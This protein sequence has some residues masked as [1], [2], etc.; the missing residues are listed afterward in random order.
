MRSPFASDSESSGGPSPSWDRTP[1]Q[2]R[3]RSTPASSVPEEDEEPEVDEGSDLNDETPSDDHP[4][5]SPRPKKSSGSGSQKQ[6]R[7]SSDGSASA[8]NPYADT[9][10]GR[11]NC[12]DLLRV[13]CVLENKDLWEKFNELGTEMIITKTGRSLRPTQA[14]F[15][16]NCG[17]M[18]RSIKNQRDFTGICSNFLPPTLPSG[19][20]QRLLKIPGCHSKVHAKDTDLVHVL[21]FPDAEAT[22]N[23]V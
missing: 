14:Y 18:Y 4:G 15:H 11:C 7:S 9:L 2:K 16:I 21:L 10:K 5:K 3:D 12:Q 23:V 8:A 19:M 20:E 1:G 13:D 22:A 6:R 17:I